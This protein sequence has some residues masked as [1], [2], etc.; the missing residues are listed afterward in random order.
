MRRGGG[1][2]EFVLTPAANP[3]LDATRIVVGEALESDELIAALNAVPSRKPAATSSVYAGVARAAGDV[4]A[5]TEQDWRP[6]LKIQIVSAELLP[7]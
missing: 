6:L 1:E 5:R 7:P 4:R 3:S 2:F